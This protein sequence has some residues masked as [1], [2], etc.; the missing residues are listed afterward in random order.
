[1]KRFLLLFAIFPFLGFSQS[2]EL[3]SLPIKYEF[4]KRKDNVSSV[5]YLEFQKEEVL[6]YLRKY[7]NSNDEL[8]REV[9][10]NKI[11]ETDYRLNI[12]ELTKRNGSSLVEWID[13]IEQWYELQIKA[14][15]AL[16]LAWDLKKINHFKG[17]L[18]S[19]HLSKYGE[20]LHQ[21]NYEKLPI[22]KQ[23]E[24]DNAAKNL[25]YSYSEL[26]DDVDERL[27]IEYL[28]YD[29]KTEFHLL[30]TKEKF[31]VIMN[32]YKIDGL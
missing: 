1:M 25:F 18:I 31:N 20:D 27:L 8:S 11:T 22:V 13:G 3:D 14:E 29:A 2:G 10:K 28:G 7:A 19:N 16:V 12:K 30:D 6:K 21:V 9:L 5:G 23:I 26:F 32:V 15:M 4:I 17:K 24:I